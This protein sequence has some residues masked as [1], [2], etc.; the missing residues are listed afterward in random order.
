MRR[1][2]LAAA[3]AAA[4]AFLA[5][6]PAMALTDTNNAGIDDLGVDISSV[7]FTRIGVQDFLS[8]LAP[9]TRQ[10]VEAACHNYVTKNGSAGVDLQTITFCQQAVGA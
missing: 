9:D 7:P 3:L 5:L 4:P 6:S 8:K 1:L 10:S 2:I